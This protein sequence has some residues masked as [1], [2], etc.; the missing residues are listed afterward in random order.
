MLRSKPYARALAV[1][2]VMVAG[3]LLAG[4]GTSGTPAASPPASGSAERGAVDVQGACAALIRVDAVPLPGGDPETPVPSEEIKQFGKAVVGPLKKAL[5]HSDDELAAHL[6]VLQPIA[7][8]AAEKGKPLPGDD[9]MNAAIAGFHG[10]AHE[11]CGYQKVDLM[12]V[13]YAFENMPASLKAGPVSL[14]MMNHSDKGEFHVAL[15]VQPKDP[16]ITTVE[17]LLAIPLPELENSVE[18]LG[19]AAAP[20]GATGGLLI[21]LGP[22]RYF[23]VCPV[24][25]AGDEGGTDM[26]M[27][28]GMASVIEVT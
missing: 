25:V 5:A 3:V 4:C 28:H 2:A 13:D 21:D 20:P 16:K 15:I 18:L 12:A 11:N 6:K 27:L 10:W 9:S 8:A 19:E 26:H 7:V 23:V 24:P 14:S 22:G 1:G 17:Q